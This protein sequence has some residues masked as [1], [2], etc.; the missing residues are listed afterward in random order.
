MINIKTKMALPTPRRVI[1]RLSLYRRL[2]I[3]SL[4]EG[5]PNVYSHELAGLAGA[6]AAQVRRDLMTIGFE[7]SPKRGYSRQGLIDSI[8][9]YLDDPAGQRL[10]LVG[11]GLLGRSIINYFVGK[12]PNLTI[13]AAFDIDPQRV[14]RVIHGCHC[15]PMEELQGIVRSHGISVGIITVPAGAAQSVADHLV[16]GGVRSIVNFAPVA[17]RVPDGV[18]IQDIDITTSLE[19]AAFYARRQD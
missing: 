19:T 2:L 11:V 9:Q 12:R 4:T 17:L 7:G 13:A 10:A 1:G 15:Y 18:F 16:G 14:N 5:S 8:G 6:S 3:R